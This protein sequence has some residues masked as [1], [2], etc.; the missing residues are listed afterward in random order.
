M[1]FEIPL[2][3][4]LKILPFILSLGIL[5]AFATSCGTGHSQ[6]RFVAASPGTT[7][8][9]PTA[10][11]VAVDGKTV[12]TALAFGGVSPD[13]GYLTVAA[14]NRRVEGRDT[15][16]T[17]DQIN[18]TVDFGSQQ[19][20]TLL[21]T[22]KM[23]DDSVAAVLKTDDNSAPASGKIK[24]RIIH[25]APDSPND[26]TLAACDTAPCVDVYVVA[27]GTDITNL[28]PM[29]SSLS[30]QQASLYLTLP[31]ATY[32]VIMTDSTNPI[33]NRLIDQTYT[34]TAGQ[35]RTL[36]TLDKPDGSTI[37]DTPLVLSDLN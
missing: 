27:P 3:R 12:V 11:D 5:A 15:G 2:L 28:T 13:T 26:G 32:E 10:L 8:V 23:S 30:Y 22:G 17:T 7:E 35:I 25:V 21:A 14:G 20:Y 6:V 33:K 4:M 34:L 31:A 16:T 18:T 36:V 19:T 29:V 24:L 9:P 1:R 37:S